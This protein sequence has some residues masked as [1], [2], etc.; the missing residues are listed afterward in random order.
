MHNK[1]RKQFPLKI[2]FIQH[3][4]T[5]CLG[6]FKS[7]YFKKY[8]MILDYIEADCSTIIEK[9]ENITYTLDSK[10]PKLIWTFWYDES[11]IKEIP[12]A[13]IARMKN[14]EGYKTIVLTKDNLSSYV[15]VSDI[16]PLL[17][18]GYISIQFFSDVLRVRVLKKYG[19]FWMDSTIAI[20]KKESIDSII[21]NLNFFSIRLWEFKKWQSVT[22]GKFSSYFWATP[23]DNLL[24]SY[25]NDCFSAFI[26]KHHTTIDYYQFD[27][28]IMA[29]YEKIKFI[30]QMIDAIPPSNPDTFWLT[31]QLNKPFSKEKWHEIQKKTDIFKLSWRFSPQPSVT[32]ENYWEHL[33]KDWGI[34]DK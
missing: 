13:C 23:P 10:I 31:R 22:E 24:F 7:L 3:L 6:L 28:T 12:K 16:K 4:V 30:R 15:D 34:Y 14:L 26:Q 17:D 27:Y 11:N 2:R 18:R 1:L 19:G 9:Y 8:R 5:M 21:Q 20:T 25:V 32:E 33:L 29:G